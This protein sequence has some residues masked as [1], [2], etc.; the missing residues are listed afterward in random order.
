VHRGPAIV[1]NFGGNRFFNYTAMGDTVNT[2]AR[3]EGANKFIGTLNCIS[4]QAA[5]FAEGYLLRPS[6]A[7]FLK[8]KNE[9]THAFEALE[10]TEENR[11]MVREYLEAYRM[12]ANGEPQ[13]EAAFETLAQKYPSD[14]LIAFHRNRLAGGEVGDDIHLAGK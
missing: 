1:G 3:L 6:G 2:A 9:C 5:T 8:G 14:T 13:A 10:D 11:A 7:L 12:M 4:D